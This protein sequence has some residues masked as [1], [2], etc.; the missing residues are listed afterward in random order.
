MEASEE[1]EPLIGHCKDWR[2]LQPHGS[3]KIMVRGWCTYPSSAFSMELR[4]KESQGPNPADLLL[5][6]IESVAEGY[7]AGA[8]RAIEAEYVE[9]TETEYDTVTILPDEVTIEVEK[10][11]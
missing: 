8:I 2:A 9:E 1:H 4:R 3:G 5:E 7:H 6:R 10:D 11:V